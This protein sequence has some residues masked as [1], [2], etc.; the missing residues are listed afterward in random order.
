LVLQGTLFEHLAESLMQLSIGLL[1][2][3]PT[4]VL[5]LCPC[6]WW[7][8]WKFSITTYWV[9]H[10]ICNC[11]ELPPQNC[12]VVIGLRGIYILRVCTE[13]EVQP[14]LLGIGR[15][16]ITKIGKCWI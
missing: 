12:I 10:I 7:K 3:F 15:I 6:V 14:F 1:F 11:I 8:L 13:S 4:T 16:L 5:T 2:I 9:W